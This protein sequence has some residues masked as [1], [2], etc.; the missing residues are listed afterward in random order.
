M[1]TRLFKTH[2]K[3]CWDVEFSKCEPNLFLSAGDD[4][5]VRLWSIKDRN[6]ISLIKADSNVCTAKFN[7]EKSNEFVYGCSDHKLYYYDMRNVSKP[8][9]ILRGHE[10]AVN[11]C[12]FINGN[13]F[14]SASVDGKIKVWKFDEDTGK[15]NCNKS[16]EGHKNSKNFV[17]LSG[18][19]RY[20]VCG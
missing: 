16:L 3:R 13:E 12:K 11:H 15:F 10:K 2:E 19:N 6:E 5:T 8:L 1:N 14:A 4:T 9:H 18:R 7:P 20:L 17:G